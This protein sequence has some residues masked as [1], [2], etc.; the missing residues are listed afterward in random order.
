LFIDKKI[1][2]TCDMT[3][4]LEEAIRGGYPILIIAED[5]E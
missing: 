3:G 1:S 4:I 2:T 5:I